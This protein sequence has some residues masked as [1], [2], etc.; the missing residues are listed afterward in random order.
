MRLVVEADVAATVGGGAVRAERRQPAQRVG[1]ADAARQRELLERV[2]RLDLSA[3]IRSTRRAGYALFAMCANGWAR[4]SGNA[5]AGGGSDA[6]SNARSRVA[7]DG[8]TRR[9]LGAHGRRRAWAPRGRSGARRRARTRAGAAAAAPPPPPELREHPLRERARRRRR[10]ARG[11]APPQRPGRRRQPHRHAVEAAAPLP[12]RNVVAE[13]VEGE[14]VAERRVR[15][16]SRARGRQRLRRGGRHLRGEHFGACGVCVVAGLPLRAALDARWRRNGEPLTAVT[17]EVARGSLAGVLDVTYRARW[18]PQHFET[19]R[20]YS[21]AR[22][23]RVP[24]LAH[25]R[26]PAR[27]IPRRDDPARARRRLAVPVAT[28]R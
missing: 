14:V 15:E 12:G 23:P 11:L 27:C 13:A 8:S 22:M 5:S 6:G 7:A 3:R 18:P 20:R 1:D 24:P 16:G 28:S 2:R 10:G 26:D 25:P 21:P 17:Q 4:G 9:E 19:A